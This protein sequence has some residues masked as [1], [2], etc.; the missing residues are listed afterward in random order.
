M[1]YFYLPDRQRPSII[2]PDGTMN[3][4]EIRTRTL[5]DISKILVVRLKIGSSLSFFFLLFFFLLVSLTKMS[6]QNKV[7]TLKF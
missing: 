3:G 1:V 4:I 6:G 2:D 5:A 7:L